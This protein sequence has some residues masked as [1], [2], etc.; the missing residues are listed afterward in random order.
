MKF[1]LQ[2]IVSIRKLFFVVAFFHIGTQHST[3]E[4]F[5]LFVC[6]C[7]YVVAGGKLSTKFELIQKFISS[8]LL[9]LFRI[10]ILFK[11][12]YV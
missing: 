10:Q 12:S 4:T 9:L 8:E 5:S 2:F 6:S 3:C 1:H 7:S 11:L